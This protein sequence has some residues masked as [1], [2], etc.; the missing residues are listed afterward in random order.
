MTP[1][2]AAAAAAAAVAVEDSS[3]AAEPHAG[4]EGTCTQAR[5][6]EAASAWRGTCTSSHGRTALGGRRSACGRCP[7]RGRC[8]GGDAGAGRRWRASRGVTKTCHSRGWHPCC[9]RD[10]GTCSAG[11]ARHGRASP[12][13]PSALAAAP[14]G[15][16]M[17]SAGGG[18]DEGGRGRTLPPRPPTAAR[19]SLRTGL[20]RRRWRRSSWRR[21]RIRAA[22][23]AAA[24]SRTGGNKRDG[25]RRGL[26]PPRSARP[27][28][29][30]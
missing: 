13:A 21:C 1:A 23:A 14:R 17:C 3:A 19:N 15:R 9:R 10:L 28:P 7:G 26:P 20:R 4:E 30:Y 2:M 24:W 16:G 8:S 18:L 11:P 25:W 6:R 27:R 22:R 12:P 29:P 5:A